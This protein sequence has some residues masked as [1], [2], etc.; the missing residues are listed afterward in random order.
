MFNNE[1][2]EIIYKT[3]NPHLANFSSENLL[4]HY[5]YYGK[6]RG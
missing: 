6:M 5:S 4:S 2:D 3:K 1:Y